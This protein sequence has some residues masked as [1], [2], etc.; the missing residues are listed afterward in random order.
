MGYL[1]E[2]EPLIKEDTPS[3]SEF[4]L[5]MEEQTSSLVTYGLENK[6]CSASCGSEKY[7]YTFDKR[8]GHIVQE[9]ISKDNLS[10][11]FAKY[12]EYGKI[13]EFWNYDPN[14]GYGLTDFGL[15]ADHLTLAVQ[16]YNCY[17]PGYYISDFHLVDVPYGQ[18]LPCLSQE[19]QKMVAES[20]GKNNKFY[21]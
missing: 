17:S 10:R 19:A 11:F 6:H 15:F 7:Y 21:K 14:Q 1:K 20:V 9:I 3:T 13:E 16:G 12:P 4:I 5:K 8:D 18:I 2:L